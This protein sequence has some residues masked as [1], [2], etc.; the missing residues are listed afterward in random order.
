M[1]DGSMYDDSDWELLDDL[2]E[3]FE[4]AWRQQGVASL[5]AFVPA[6]DSPHRQRVLV[7]LVKVDQEFHWAAGQPRRL[8]DYLNDWPELRADQD[9]LVELLEAECRTRAA[10]GSLPQ[11]SELEARFPEWADRLDLDA[12]A[13]QAR[14]DEP[15]KPTQSLVDTPGHSEHQTHSAPVTARL[16][17][18]GEAFGAESRYT[19]LGVLGVGGMGVVYRARDE[20][21][22]REVALKIPRTNISGS[23]EVLE[24]FRREFQA[25]ADSSIPISVISTM[26][27]SGRAEVM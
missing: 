15:S 10:L 27:G 19:I 18:T 1:N 16:L 8:E 3:R 26:R 12:I 23:P 17:S 5:E 20:L 7:E 9:V 21:L 22:G 11:R 2:V 13:D 4:E 25:A 14:A 6:P 24:R